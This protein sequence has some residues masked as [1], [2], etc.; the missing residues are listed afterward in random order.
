M[1]EAELTDYYYRKQVRIQFL[2]NYID[3][4]DIEKP[5]KTIIEQTKRIDIDNHKNQVIYAEL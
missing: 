3:Y 1:D 5:V 2:K 4:E